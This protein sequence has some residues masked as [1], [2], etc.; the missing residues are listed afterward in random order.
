[1][2]VVCFST[3]GCKLIQQCFS[4]SSYLQFLCRFIML[5][6]SNFNKSPNGRKENMLTL[7]LFAVVEIPF[8]WLM[9]G[10]QSVLNTDCLSFV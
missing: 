9:E 8:V 3:E 10:L 7:E 5:V 1:M 4:L 6:V 2:P